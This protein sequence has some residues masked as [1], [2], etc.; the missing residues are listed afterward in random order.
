MN[1]NTL[2][3]TRKMVRF[4]R[5]DALRRRAALRAECSEERAARWDA[6]AERRDADR[7][8]AAS[9]RAD[10]VERSDA[11]RADRLYTAASAAHHDLW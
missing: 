4:A 1:T 10:A 9:D 8:D 7:W 11:D 6:V 3:L 2:V 5:L